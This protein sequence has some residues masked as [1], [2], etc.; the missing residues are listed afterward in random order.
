M[1]GFGLKPVFGVQPYPLRARKNNKNNG[2]VT[3]FLAV[4]CRYIEG[5][6]NSPVTGP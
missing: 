1:I 4:K 2:T 5:S 6:K 3:C